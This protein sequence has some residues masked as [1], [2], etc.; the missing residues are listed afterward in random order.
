MSELKNALINFFDIY[1]DKKNLYL[2]FK[3]DILN[4]YVL[5]VQL[6]KWKYDTIRL[7]ED[8]RLSYW[9]EFSENNLSKSQINLLR[10]WCKNIFVVKTEY[11]PE[12][13]IIDYDFNDYNQFI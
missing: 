7:R 6:N 4:K 2:R 9:L 12:I 5:N 11:K 8:I 10:K 1:T 13:G 3:K